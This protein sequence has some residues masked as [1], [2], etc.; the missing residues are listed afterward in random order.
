[1]EYAYYGFHIL[2]EVTTNDIG[3]ENIFKWITVLNFI[4]H[5]KYT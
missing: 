1:M 4:F 5:A 3:V 2:C